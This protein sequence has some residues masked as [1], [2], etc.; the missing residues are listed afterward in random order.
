[1]ML[2]NGA[3]VNVNNYIKQNG[4]DIK[5]T[6]SM[7]RCD[8]KYIDLGFANCYK[9]ENSFTY[10]GG[11]DPDF[12]NSGLGVKADIAMLSYIYKLHPYIILTTGVYKF[13]IRSLKLTKAVGFVPIG[14]TEDTILYRMSKSSFDNPFVNRVLNN[15]FV[16]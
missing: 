13:N 8:G 16:E 7:L 5:Y 10:V 11:I 2:Y 1:M 14:E 12:F 3:H 6:L 9:G 4:I 15:V